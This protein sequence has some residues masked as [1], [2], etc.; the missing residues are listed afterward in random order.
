[1]SENA[2]NLR[3]YQIQLQQVEA[4]LLSDAD[5]AEL[6]KLKDDLLVSNLNLADYNNMLFYLFRKWL[7]W[8]NN[9]WPVRV[10]S[11]PMPVPMLS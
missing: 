2:A 5:N 7:V 4:A 9:W 8:P 11:T 10:R 6:V 3:N 1:M